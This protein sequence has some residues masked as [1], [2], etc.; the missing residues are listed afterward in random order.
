VST[1]QPIGAPAAEAKWSAERVHTRQ[2]RTL[3]CDGHHS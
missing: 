3:A 2:G 1:D